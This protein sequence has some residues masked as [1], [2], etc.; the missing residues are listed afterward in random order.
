MAHA[1][2]RAMVSLL[3]AGALFQLTTGLFNV[4]YWYPFPFFFPA[5]HYWTAYIA[6][7]A[8]LIHVA[9]EWAKVRRL[10]D[11]AQAAEPAGLSR[12]GFFVTVAG[13]CGLVAIT[14]VGET[15]TPLAR[16]AVLAPRRPG[17]GTQR[18]PVNTTAL[19][20]GVIRKP[21]WRLAVTGAVEREL[22]LSLADLRA[23][24]RHLV[25]LPIACVEGWSAEATWAGVRL[26]D[27]LHAAGVAPDARVRVE[28]LQAQGR[29]RASQ[30]DAPDWHDELTLLALEVNG[31]PLALDHG[32]PCRLIAPDRPGVMQTKWVAKLVVS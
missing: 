27:V 24:P 3:V 30:V 6:F 18:L 5:A 23:L 28:S 17:V 22:S 26:R 4:A 9:G 12:R 29:Y 2:Q 10:R 32:Y 14:T 21:D 19:A 8:L 16:L 11:A 15:F 31:E 25:R 20:A 7:G 13:A 1:A